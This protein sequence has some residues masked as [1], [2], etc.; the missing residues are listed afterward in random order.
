MNKDYQ[1]GKIIIILCIGKKPSHHSQ[2][3]FLTALFQVNLGLASYHS[4]L[5]LVVLQE[6]IL[7]QEIRSMERVSAEC[8]FHCQLIAHGCLFRIRLPLTPSSYLSPFSKYSMCNFSD[9][10]L[11][12]FKAIQVNVHSAN[13]KSI[14][15]SYLTSIVSNIVALTIFDESPVT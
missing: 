1:L 2:H 10:E 3:L 12:H 5:S 8:C 9:L 15:V 14:V 4:V 13:R 7:E 6:T 11:G